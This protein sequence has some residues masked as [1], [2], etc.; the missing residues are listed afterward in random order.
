MSD[1]EPV[2]EQTPEIAPRITLMGGYIKR[3][4]RADL[5]GDYAGVWVEVWV[6]CPK[7][8]ISAV[9]SDNVTRSD[10]AMATFILDHNLQYPIDQEMPDAPPDGAADDWAASWVPAFRAGEPMP[11]PITAEAVGYIPIDLYRKIVEAGMQA[12]QK[13]GE[14]TKRG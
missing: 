2:R 11:R 7:R 8:L 10:T 14:V 6:N 4:V 12:L 1:I 3:R 13:A 5:D 9:A